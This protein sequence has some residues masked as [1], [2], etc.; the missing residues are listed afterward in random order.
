MIRI[1]HI[2]NPVKVPHQS[3]LHIAQPITFESMKIAREFARGSV[4]VELWSSQ[5]REDREIIPDFFLKTDDLTSSI[6]DLKKFKIK[7]KLPFIKDILDELEKNSRAEFFIYTNADIALMPN[8]YLSVAAFI[9]QGYDA[10]AI[11]RRTITDKYKYVE[12]LPLMYAEAGEKHPGWDCFIFKRELYPRFNLGKGIVGQ[13]WIG[14]IVLSNLILNARKFNVFQNCH[15]TFHI[16]D[17]RDWKRQ[18]Y[19]DYQEH[20]MN[21]CRNIL[22]TYEKRFGVLDRSTKPGEFLKLYEV[23]KN[24]RKKSQYE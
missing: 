17:E 24:N 14:R 2:I 15:L 18:E 6:L 22:L 16:G 1:G 20:N 10:F 9:N 5:Y 3:D 7:R 21:E 12:E 4:E 8:F 19:A 23:K 11:N 13:G